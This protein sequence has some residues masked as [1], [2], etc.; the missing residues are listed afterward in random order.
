[1]SRRKYIE[2]DVCEEE[3]DKYSVVWKIKRMLLRG[4]ITKYKTNTMDFRRTAVPKHIC[5]DCWNEIIEIVG[6]QTDD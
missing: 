4:C 2:C 3:I 5:D 1:M 6:E